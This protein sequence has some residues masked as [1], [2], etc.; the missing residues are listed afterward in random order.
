M[1]KKT[2]LLVP[3]S[4]EKAKA[5]QRVQD[6]W[7]RTATLRFVGKIEK[8]DNPPNKDPGKYFGLEYD[9]PSNN[10]ERHNGT[11]GEKQY[12]TCEPKKGL[13]AKVADDIYE[14]VNPEG[15]RQLRKHFG[16]RVAS[17]HD[18]ELVKFCI[19]RQFE[20]DKVVEMLEKHLQWRADFKPNAEE[21]FPPTIADDYPCGY[22]GTADYD[23]NLIYCERPSNAGKCHPSD[24]VKKYTLPVIARWHA[25]GVEM[26]IARMRASNYAHKRVCYVIDLLNVKALTTPMIGFAQTLASV[27]QDNYPE[28][29]GRVFIVNCPGFFRF[30]WNLIKI[31]IDSRTN[32]KIHFVAPNHAIKHM[33]PCMPEEDIPNFCGGVS[34]KWME[35]NQGVIGSHDPLKAFRGK[36]PGGSQKGSQKGSSK[37]DNDDSLVNVDVPTPSSYGSP[38]YISPSYD[39]PPAGGFPSSKAA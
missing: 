20:M 31:F 39:S 35:T 30:A 37:D 25:T 36:L 23:E 3:V 12:F 26:G 22:T 28:N 18:F 1:A 33:T 24:F 5:G 11:W 16:E 27:E 29:L 38:S 19:A 6:Y 15:I 8:K 21:Y 13:M 34:N 9:E 10:T 32:K 7:G 17:W 2:S 14:E 4:F